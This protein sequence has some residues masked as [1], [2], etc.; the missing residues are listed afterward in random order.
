MVEA[1][2]HVDL[3]GSKGVQIGRGLNIQFNRF[4]LGPAAGEGTAD[5]VTAI[6]QPGG[7]LRTA[8]KWMLAVDI[9][10]GVAIISG[11]SLIA[12]SKVHGI[13]HALLAGTGLVIAMGGVGLAVW[14]TSKVLSP[15]L[16]TPQALRSPALAGLCL[17]IEAEP[18]HFFGGMATTVD[19]LLRYREIAV[20]LARSTTAE[21]DPAR[22]EIIG[23]QLRRAQASAERADSYVRWVL[24]QA[25]VWQVRADLQRSGWYTLVAGLVVVAGMILVFVAAGI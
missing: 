8:A 9:A 18:E 20:N 2:P 13:A 24:A 23:R 11:G 1:S 22:R 15:R 12:L 17:I 3:H 6:A 19:D 21:R 7:Q 14:Y 16:I 25:L 4:Q 10:V 5:Q